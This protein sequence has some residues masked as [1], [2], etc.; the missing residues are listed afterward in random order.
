MLEDNEYTVEDILIIASRYEG[1]KAKDAKPVKIAPWQGVS[2]MFAYGWGFDQP[3]FYYWLPKCSNYSIKKL[4]PEYRALE[5][6]TLDELEAMLLDSEAIAEFKNLVKESIA[7]ENKLDL[8]REQEQK[9]TNYSIRSGRKAAVIRQGNQFRVCYSRTGGTI[10]RID[11]LRYDSGDRFVNNTPSLSEEDVLFAFSQIEEGRVQ[12]Y[13]NCSSALL[14]FART[15]W[16]DK[17]EIEGSRAYVYQDQDRKL[18]TL[19]VESSISASCELMLMK[20]GCDGITLYSVAGHT[21]DYRVHECLQDALADYSS[22][23]SCKALRGFSYTTVEAHISGYTY[24]DTITIVLPHDVETARGVWV[25][26]GTHT[27]VFEKSKAPSYDWG[28]TRYGGH[29]LD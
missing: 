6:R 7:H 28:E 12:F 15:F 21:Q 19:S 29:F 4:Y 18:T 2:I 26:S 10:P 23:I 17:A 25:K 16:Y 3:H 27:I 14:D 1:Q 11:P 9:R 22:F 8:E 13:K 5:A 24:E 20:N